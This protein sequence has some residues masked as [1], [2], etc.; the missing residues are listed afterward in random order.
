MDRISESRAPSKATITHVAERAGVSI[1]TVSRYINQTVPVA[2][3]TAAAIQSAILE[4]KYIPSTAA[5]NLASKKT[6]TIGLILPDLSSDFFP[7]MLRGIDAGARECGFGLLIST[8]DRTNTG[9][10]LYRPLGDHNTDGLLIF[11]DSL[12]EI[13]LIWHYNLRFPMVLLYQSPPNGLNIPSVTFEN[14]A[15]SHKLVDHLIEVHQRRRIAYLRGPE[16]NEDSYWREMGYREAL[17]SHNIPFDPTLIGEGGFSEEGGRV[18]MRKWLDENIDIDAIF[19]GDDTTASGVITI[20]KEAGKRIPEDIS[21][22][23]FDDISISRYLTP[24][25]TTIRAPI[26]AAGYEATQQLVCLIRN[27][28]VEPLTLLP[29]EIVIRH[30]CGRDCNTI[31]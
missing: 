27:E 20:L 26:E 18:Q 25:L 31:A 14:K 13:E 16:R 23:G 10:G 17:E 24:P 7:P 4:L 5:K 22:V 21:V 11:T 15:G 28:P 12:S 30:S 1:T 9:P 29:T 3:E 19:A 8:Q 6:S 2:E